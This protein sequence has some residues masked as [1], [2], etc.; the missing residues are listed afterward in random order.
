MRKPV[1]TAAVLG[2]VAA[3]IVPAGVAQAAPHAPAAGS[4]SI[5]MKVTGCNGCTITPVQAIEGEDAIWSGAAVKVKGGKALLTVP[6]ARTRGMSFNLE[7]AWNVAIN[8]MP[9]IVTQYESTQPGQSVTKKQAMTFTRATGCW[10]GTTEPAVTVNVTV[11]RVTMPA[12][13]PS[14]KKKTTRVPLAWMVPTQSTTGGFDTASKG[15]IA[16]QNAWYCPD[17]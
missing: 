13:P 15:V 4:T 9:V 5:T 6:T 3:M 2:V 12:F 16:Q 17:A 1:A 7:A 10:A 14:G 11:R 8:A